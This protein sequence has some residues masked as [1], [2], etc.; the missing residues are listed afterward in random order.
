MDWEDD[1]EGAKTAIARPNELPG[2]IAAR[3]AAVASRRPAP[4]PLAFNALEVEPAAPSASGTDFQ[5]TQ[6]RPQLSESAIDLE[7]VRPR[8]TGL[9]LALLVLAGLAVLGLLVL[10]DVVPLPKL[11]G[12]H[13]VGARGVQLSERRG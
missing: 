4:S 3:A 9:I 10:L 13:R 6:D 7:A 1:D 12:G 11:G 8:R 2:L 5:P